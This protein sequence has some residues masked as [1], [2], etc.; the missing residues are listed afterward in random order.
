[1][2]KKV[3]SYLDRVSEGCTEAEF[4]RE[5]PFP[6]LVELE[7]QAG[8]AGD[9]GMM[10]ERLDSQNIRL[11]AKNSRHANVLEIRGQDEKATS[12]R[13]G[14]A[15][16]SDLNVD[17]GS[18]SKGHAEFF[19]DGS[20]LKLMDLGSTNGTFINNRRLEPNKAESVSADDTVRFGLATGFYLLHAPGFFQYLT[21][22]QRFG[23]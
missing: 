2:K 12:V 15:D 20:S 13:V 23:L 9:A 11:Q 14:R 7:G 6:V 21:T 8:G 22:L 16:L 10:T 4:V 19:L 3:Q 18:V 1:V 17:H 5:F